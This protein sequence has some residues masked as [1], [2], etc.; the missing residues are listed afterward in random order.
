M[1]CYDVVL[2]KHK[3][4]FKITASKECKIGSFQ[5]WEGLLTKCM[6]ISIFVKMHHEGKIFLNCF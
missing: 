2:L 5:S 6:L 1:L 3:K 4:N